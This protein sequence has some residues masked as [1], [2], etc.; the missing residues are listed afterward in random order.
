MTKSTLWAAVG[1][2]V[3]LTPAMARAQLTPTVETT[4][5][6]L[7]AGVLTGFT[8]SF[9][10]LEADE[11]PTEWTTSFASGS[12]DFDAYDV[13]DVVATV[14]LEA[15]ISLPLPIGIDLD[16]VEIGLADIVLTSVDPA[17]DIFEADL[18]LRATTGTLGDPDA[19]THSVTF[20]NLTDDAEITIEDLGV[21]PAPAAL[22][23][24]LDFVLTFFDILD[25]DA[26]A[27]DV[28]TTV[29]SALSEFESVE[30]FDVTG[31][32]GT[33][34]F[35]RGDVDG[36]GTVSALLDSLR[37]LNWAF[38]GGDPLPCDDAADAD[39]NNS[40]SALLDSLTI[41]Q[42]TF[43][44]GIAPADPGP[45]ECGVDPDGDGDG[46]LCEEPLDAGC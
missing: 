43:A 11:A 16:I 21:I 25:P 28:V 27:L 39:G 35:L 24:D 40:V 36:N 32:A 1:L 5:D 17:G 15:V 23:S 38:N 2:V 29:S 10:F 19:V 45:L 26:G 7:E 46:L 9:V 8:Q 18:I 34:L 31:D 44:G 14:E 22:F 3:L 42:W 33:D 13:D 4:I 20:S 12:F 30:L 6:T 41:L 37:L